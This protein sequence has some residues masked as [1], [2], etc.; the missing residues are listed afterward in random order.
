MSKKVYFPFREKTRNIY[1]K[2][3]NISRI[4]KTTSHSFIRQYCS[5]QELLAKLGREES[6]WPC[7][8]SPWGCGRRPP[9][10]P[11][12]RRPWRPAGRA[13]SAPQWTCN[14]DDHVHNVMI[15]IFFPSKA[16][17]LIT[18][19]YKSLVAFL[20]GFLS[21]NPLGSC[22]LGKLLYLGVS[23]TM[24]HICNMYIH[25]W[26]PQRWWRCILQGAKSQLW[27]FKSNFKTGWMW[28]KVWNQ[29]EREVDNLGDPIREEGV[30]RP[31]DDGD[32][33]LSMC[34]QQ[35]LKRTHFSCCLK[36]L[37]I[38]V[39]K[40]SDLSKEWKHIFRKFIKDHSL[41]MFS[42][43]LHT[44]TIFKAIFLWYPWLHWL[45][46]L[47]IPIVL[48]DAIASLSMG[49]STIVTIVVSDSFSDFSFFTNPLHTSFKKCKIQHR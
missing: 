39:W 34:K 37:E 42:R 47:I 8:P 35:R 11:G 17:N 21:I 24:V 30:D 2:S 26:N 9:W 5:V 4:L 46:V 19:L 7:P 16:Y 22:D 38:Y 15:R 10:R 27:G 32:H 14:I 48:L 40:F 20:P 33:Q 36:R 18:N 1:F 49:H 29:N 45:T 31:K 13:Q 25:T 44:K 28:M 41:K 12:R 6:P 3:Q 43:W 23:G